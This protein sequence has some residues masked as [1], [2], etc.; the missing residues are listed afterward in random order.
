VAS[1]TLV[2]NLNADLIDGQHAA[3]FQNKYG[4]I[5]VVA[6]SGGDYSDP[7]TALSNLVSWCGVPSSTNPCLLKIMPGIYTVSSAVVM[8]PYVDIEGS[9]EKVTKITAALS[10]ATAPLTVATVMGA[11]NAELRF[12]TIENTGTGNN[13]TA[14]LNTLA[15]PSIIHVTATALGAIFVNYGVYNYNS[16][17][18]TMTNVTA[19]ASGG[20]NTAAGVFN[21][22]NSSPKTTNL[23]AT[24]SGS[25]NWSV[26]IFNRTSSLTLTNVTAT[27]SGGAENY[28]IVNASS[29]TVKINHSII[30]G[31]SHTIA[32]QTGVVTLVANTQLDGGAVSN[33]GTITCAGV[34]DENYTFYASTCP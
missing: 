9:G 25:S 26:G 2:P 19:T 20:S 5:A 8:Q 30:K 4:K 6:Q 11:D 29:G 1:T 18:P 24:G 22:L 12:L 13:T 34:Y 17:S 33:G 15:S 16:S 14:L 21:E 23:T 27:A 10:S 31:A 28:G 3:N 7:V 32:N